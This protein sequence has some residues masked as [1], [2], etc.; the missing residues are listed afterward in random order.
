MNAIKSIFQLLLLL[1][2]QIIIF[3]NFL[4]AGYLNPYVYIAFILFLPPRVSP[5]SLLSIAFLVGASLDVFEGAYGVHT[6]ASV[7]IA[8]IKPLIFRVF[9]AGKNENSEVVGINQLGLL[10]SLGFV[11]LGLFIHHFVLFSLENFGFRNF[12]I[13]ILRSLYS[14]LFS[15]TFVLLYQLWNYRR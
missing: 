4:F 9:R 11:L 1:G 14:A 2:L 6:A 7:F 3:N 8:F 5:I 15:F 10:R 13:L 12:D